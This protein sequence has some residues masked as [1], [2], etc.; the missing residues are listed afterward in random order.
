MPGQRLLFVEDEDAVRKMIAGFLERRGYEVV[1][2]RDGIEALQA[3]R[4]GLPDLVVTDVNMPNMN[5]LELTRRLRAHH[6]TARLPIVMLSA[7]KDES[8][9]LA[10]YAEGA[11]EYAPK[12]IELAVLA[13]KIEILLRRSGGPEGRR[14]RG[15]LF[16]FIHGKGG[17]GTTTVAVNVAAA[18]AAGGRGRVSLLD[19]NFEF[20]AA[21]MFFNM[22]PKHT[23]ADLS[24][25]AG[26]PDQDDFEMFVSRDPRTGVEVVTGADVPERAEL[27]TIPAVNLAIDR[28][29]ERSEVVLADSPPSFSE[30]SLCALDLAEMACLVTSP[31]LPAIKATLDWMKVLQKIDFPNAR[32]LLVV[33][34]TTPKGYPVAEIERVFKRP[35]DAVIPYSDLF[36]QAANDGRPLVSANAG[37]PAAK[38]LQDLGGRLASP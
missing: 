38:E 28:L 35:L 29:R 34:Q 14:T 16:M 4:D 19:L 12:P 30:R 1:A 9:V 3:I 8:D 24:E 22:R 15:R 37:H 10:G 5:G 17:V 13:A 23:L 25:A 27:V 32:L 20:P 36:D 11:D 18:L 7:M 31:H 26:R 6:R 33:S 2:V 21:A